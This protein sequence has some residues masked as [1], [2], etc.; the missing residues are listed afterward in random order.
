MTGNDRTF[1][2]F[3]CFVVA[4]VF[5]PLIGRAAAQHFDAGAQ[6]TFAHSGEFDST[7]T[8]IGARLSWR[9]AEMVAADAEID[10]FPESFANR[11]PFSRRRVEG[12]FGVIAGPRLG[13]LRPF[14]KVRPGFARFRGAPVVCIQ[15][16]PPPLSCLLAAGRTL[17]ALDIGGGVDVSTGGPFV[18]RFDAGDRLLKYPGPS[19]R[20]GGRTAQDSFFGHDLRV[21]VG[22]GVTF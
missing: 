3:A 1:S 14:A 20:G 11:T 13:S 21:S 12:L 10:V 4:L 19:F 15:I 18:V 5:V 6:V 9:L 8:G 17:F 7:D 22:A 16:F 2:S